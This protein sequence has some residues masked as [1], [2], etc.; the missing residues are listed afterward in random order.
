MTPRSVLLVTP[1]WTR[2]GGVATHV[3]SS[4]TELARR[5]LE[6]HVLAARLELSEEIDG[7]TLHRS[8]DLFNAGATPRTRIGSAG[9]LA[10]DV[11]HSH[12]FEDPEVLAALGARAPV[13]ISVHGYSACASGV[14]YFR[15][16]Q[17]CSRAHG[18]GCVPNLLLRGCAHTRNPAGIPSSYQRA[19]RS[20]R[21]LQVCDLAISYSSVVDAH[22]EAAGLA[23]RA[24]VPLFPTIPPQA[25]GGHAERRRVV[26]AGRVVAPKGIDV[27]IRC[28]PDVAA[29]F[30]ICGEGRQ[31]EAMRSLAQKTGVGDRV[32]FAGWLSAAELAGEL[33]E[34][35][36]LA[37]P[38]RWPEPAG[39][40]G[41]EAQ[42]AG[43]PVI[44]SETGGVRDWLEHGV[45]G[46]YVPPGDPRALAGALN[47]LLADPDRQRALGEA[48]RRIVAERYTPAR[49]VEALLDAYGRAR[50]IWSQRR[51]GQGS[52]T[53][54][55]PTAAGACT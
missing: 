45:N 11:I 52:L 4:A 32:R 14:H 36:V 5:G 38:S 17:E 24:R 8:P 6:V 20:L 3:V 9:S 28:A 22:L 39:L 21:A 19:A 18:P 34:A 50:Q 47:E 41:L 51:G 55:R 53:T 46:L 29:D 26:F 44:A 25:A 27:L 49:H 10:P 48:G 40:V 12:Q 16:G 30:V 31:L 35:S 13:A 15:P 1:R 37:M 43:R 7:V 54:G 23:R 2:D 33:A 42:A